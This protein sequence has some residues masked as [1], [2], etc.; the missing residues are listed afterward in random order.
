MAIIDLKAALMGVSMGFLAFL[1]I[2]VLSGACAWGFYPGQKLPGRR[3]QKLLICALGGF[4]ACFASS[5]LGQFAGY[6]HS[7]QMI[8][9]IVVSLAASLISAL[10]AI[11]I[12]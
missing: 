1:L 10:M 6:F 4:A 11:L 5:Y 12:K 8:E 9:W 2:G 7:G 3:F